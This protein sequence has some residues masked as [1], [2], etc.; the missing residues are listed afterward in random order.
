MS[1]SAAN[2]IISVTVE[3]ELKQ[4]YLA[5]AMSVIVAR[6]Q[7]GIICDERAE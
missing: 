6:A 5:Y 3:K 1:E 4:S 2:E 7:T